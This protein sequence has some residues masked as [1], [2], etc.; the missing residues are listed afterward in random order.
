MAGGGGGGGNQVTDQL[1]PSHRPKT[2]SVAYLLHTRLIT[3]AGC[4]HDRLCFLL[5]MVGLN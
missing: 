1:H 5:H 3:S 4:S 2:D